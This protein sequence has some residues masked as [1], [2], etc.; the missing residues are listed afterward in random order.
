MLQTFFASVTMRSNTSFAQ[1]LYF[2]HIVD[3]RH[4]RYFIA[5]AEE[6]S[7]LRASERLHIS[8]PPLSTQIRELEESLD[9]TLFDRS[10]RGVTLTAAGKVFYT[11]ALTILA[12]VEHA[13]ISAKRVAH[14]E[15]GNLSLGFISLADYNVLPPALRDF[16]SRFPS[17]GVQLHELTTDAQI[18]ELLAE[19]IDAGIG[20]APVKESGIEFI[21]LFK[22]ELMLAV[23]AEHKFADTG[24]PHSL[25]DFKDEEFVMTPRSVGPGL[26]DLMIS[27]C[28]ECGFTPKI[29]Q[30][31]RQMQTVIS[32][33]SSGFGVALVPQS[34]KTLQRKG[35]AYVELKEKSLLLQIGLLHRTHD[36]NPVIQTF[37]ECIRTSYVKND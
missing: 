28:H 27:L 17:V 10:P 9:A 6:R 18:K 30:Y 7:F 37:L 3:L 14:G 33:V 23:P 35:V 1:H 34:L 12:R 21:P 31:A 22:D 13:K 36:D 25:E 24:M 8:Q 5:V 15:D 2:I 20:L 4:L 32:L 26:H 29:A 19:R 11:E 16:R